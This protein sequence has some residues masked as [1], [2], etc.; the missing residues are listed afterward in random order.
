MRVLILSWEYPPHVVG[1]LGRHVADLVPALVDLGV[2]VH[3]VTPL[4]AGGELFEEHHGLTVHRVSPPQL[5]ASDFYTGVWQTNLR[6]EEEGGRICEQLDIQLLHDHDWLTAF[7]AAALKRNF[8]L[9]LLSTIHATEQ[10]RSRGNLAS[11]QQRAI[12]S[13]E[14][15]L[16]YES[17]RVIC[18]AQFMANEVSTYF[19]VPTDKIDVIPNGVDAGRFARLD[20]LDLGRFRSMYALPGE[21]LI[22][23]VGR[24]VSEK[25][26][27]VL[28][29]AVPLVLAE[30]PSAKFV[31]AGT[32]DMLAT[33]RRRAWDLGVGDKVL[34][35]GY[36]SDED[37]DR[38]YKIASCAVFPSLY[39]P[40]GIVALEAMAA[41]TP[42]VVSRVGGLQEV[43]DHAET[44][45]TV[46]PDN[47]ESLAWGINHT[48]ARPDWALQRA[49]KAYQQV[50][51]KYSWESIAARTLQVYRRVI[52]ERAA[53]EW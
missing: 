17:W 4:W 6:L 31:I 32:G 20:G 2:E 13:V 14:W 10:G 51:G 19:K 44:G 22:L 36:I 24:V 27:H 29:E 33:L 26:L 18:C 37:R 35:T 11:D 12:H 45:I 42:V 1:G 39:E 52:D 15:W 30:N 41:R 7:S 28:V 50:V 16:T 49:E 34:F 46:Y 25:G 9:P 5:P 43:I 21:K 3:V 40:F 23:Y 8:R 38:L 48:L 53:S 47:I